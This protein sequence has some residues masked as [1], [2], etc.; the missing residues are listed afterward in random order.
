MFEKNVMVDFLEKCVEWTGD[1]SDY[2]P[3]LMTVYRKF[4]RKNGRQALPGLI[5]T[6]NDKDLLPDKL[7]RKCVRINKTETQVYTRIRIR[8]GAPI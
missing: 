5:K 4:C 3:A 7:E 6:I 2:V 8:P 1:E